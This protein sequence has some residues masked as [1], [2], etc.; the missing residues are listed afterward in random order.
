MSVSPALIIGDAL[1]WS[2]SL[3]GQ[4]ADQSNVLAYF[5][6]QAVVIRHPCLSATQIEAIFR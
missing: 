3:T 6:K 1:F 2:D 5:F 4:T